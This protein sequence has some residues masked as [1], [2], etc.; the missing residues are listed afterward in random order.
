M[1][2]WS[3]VISTVVLEQERMLPILL[4]LLDTDNEAELRPL[5][6]LLRNLAR[7]STNKDHTGESHTDS[8]SPSR[9]I[10]PTHHHIMFRDSKI[11]LS[12]YKTLAVKCQL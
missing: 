2:Q 9:F 1:C 5:T 12:T 7:N 4:D 8:F 3:A 11:Y 10:T 6:G